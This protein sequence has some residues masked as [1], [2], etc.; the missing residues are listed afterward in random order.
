MTGS[1]TTTSARDVA[2]RSLR[3]ERFEQMFDSSATETSPSPASPPATPQFT[4][5][6]FAAAARQSLSADS[7]TFLKQSRQTRGE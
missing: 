2:G 6:V 4:D 3:Q 1:T 7:A 5:P